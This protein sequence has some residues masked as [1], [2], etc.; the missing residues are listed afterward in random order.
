MLVGGGRED[1]E[2]KAH[3]AGGA[4]QA[5]A[6]GAGCAGVGIEG[7]QGGAVGMLA[8][9]A[10]IASA[11]VVAHVLWPPVRPLLDIDALLDL[12]H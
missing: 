5:V 10:R 2:G 6:E 3:A 8:T 4:A 1:R 12:G 7:G 11:V 9:K